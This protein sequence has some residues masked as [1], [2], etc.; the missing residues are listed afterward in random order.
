MVQ[1]KT[2]LAKQKKGDKPVVAEI[3]QTLATPG[4]GDSMDLWDN[5]GIPLR[6]LDAMFRKDG[7][8]A[9]LYRLITT[10]IRRASFIIHPKHK[11][12]NREAN[13]IAD[14]FN[15]S[16]ADGGMRIPIHQ[17][18]A[19]IL[20]MM[21]DGWA[22]HEIVWRIDEDGFVRV[23]KIAHRPSNS[24]RV[25]L[26][27]H[28]EITGYHQNRSIVANLLT[29]KAG[30]IP[31]PA[32]KMLHFV[33]GREFNAIFGRSIFTQAFYHF[34]KKHKLYYISHVAAQIRALGLRMVTAP[35]E[36]SPENIKKFMDMVAKLGFNSTILVPDKYTLELLAN[37]ASPIDAMPMINHHDSQ[38]GK[39]VLA[40]VLDLGAEGSSGSFKLSD[41]HQNIFIDN[42][43]LISR[44]IASVINNFLIPK[45][46][47]WNFGTKNYPKLE[48]LPFDKRT[49]TTISSLYQRIATG[50]TLNTTPQFFLEL[51][52][53][54]AADLNLDIDYEPI[55][56]ETI[57]RLE[58]KVEEPLNK[59]PAGQVAPATPAKT[60]NNKKE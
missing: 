47:D 39:S 26:N 27:S 46:I 7:Q 23:D 20:R 13:F 35:A 48:F 40:Q 53:Q 31:I 60:V 56:D 50:R 29:G 42:L 33:Y 12:A 11:R 16:Y 44:D 18:L 55:E 3:G 38:M 8:V 49:Q 6:K 17:V 30:E 52:K 14:I 15:N 32:D 2:A 4:F 51:E 22:P 19:T 36:E 9:G 45:L 54:V 24:M 59:P 34:E 10:P 41:T 37:S 25:T 28:G 1:A 21:L 5:E 43:E 57:E 58:K